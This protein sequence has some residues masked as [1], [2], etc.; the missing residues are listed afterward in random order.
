MRRTFEQINSMNNVLNN[1]NSFQ[2]PALEGIRQIQASQAMLRNTVTD[3]SRTG[4]ILNKM[5]IEISSSIEIPEER[6]H[7][8]KVREAYERE[9]T[10]IV[11][12][13][14][15]VFFESYVSTVLQKYYQKKDVDQESIDF[16]DG[17]TYGRK[18]Q[19][20][21][22]LGL[23]EEKHYCR[24]KNVKNA[25]DKYAHD[26]SYYDL[27]EETH[28]E[29]GSRL[30]NAIKTYQKLLGKLGFTISEEDKIVED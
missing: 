23:I 25:R 24:I 9:Q 3:W 8:E 13:F 11:I 18:L 10:E 12:I 17:Q 6:I 20:A 22:N 15:N 1:I 14:L 5:A 19:L 27:N 2:S 7:M 28:I 30:E 26:I 29:E 21:W 4:K 16:V